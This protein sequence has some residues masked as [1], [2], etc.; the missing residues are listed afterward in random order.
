ME[1]IRDF[2]QNQRRVF[3]H[4]LAENTSMFAGGAVRSGKSFATVVAFASWVCTET[5]G[6]DYGFVGQSIET[7][8]RN[9]GFDFI[10]ISRKLGFP[11]E[12]R[13]DV[14]TRIVFPLRNGESHNMWIFGANDAKARKR[15]QGATLK[16]LVV[17]ELPL[18][19]KDFFFMAWS[20]LSV[21]GAKMWASYNPE[22]P[23]HW[24]KRQVIDRC[25]EFEGKVVNF[26]MQDNPT[27]DQKTIDRYKK[28]FTGHFK[29]RYIR[30]IWAGA[31]GLIFPEWQVCDEKPFPE[32]QYAISLDWGVSSVFCALMIN[33]NGLRDVKVIDELY[34]DARESG[35]PRTESQHLDALK[36]WARRHMADFRHC[37]LYV[38]PNTPSSFKQLLKKEGFR[39]RHAD[40]DVNIGLMVTSNRLEV[41][42][43][44]ICRDKCK[45]LAEEM[46]GYIWDEKCTDKGEDKPLK[47]N[48]HACDALRYFAYSTGK[49]NKYMKP[50]KVREV[51]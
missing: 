3:E 51:L 37:F 16:G 36:A 11:A 29:E 9:I 30:G 34:Y 8:M 25:S 6:Y 19:P 10:E 46:L 18:L 17:E 32:G 50:T 12:L 7:V 47:V 44:K 20:R 38:D 48:D 33:Y 27:L 45:R 39:L 14:G 49:I 28:S 43:I 23:A 40:N 31:T 21:S 4:A 42:N 26:Q 15:I 13:K 2:S 35:Q 5:R 22:G 24:A 1:E 41:G